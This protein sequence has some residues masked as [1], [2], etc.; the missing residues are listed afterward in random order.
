[1][2]EIPLVGEDCSFVNEFMG[3][4][5]TES[6]V[7]TEDGPLESSKPEAVRDIGGYNENTSKM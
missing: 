3:L 6:D 2:G 4:N 5:T 7:C 1:M